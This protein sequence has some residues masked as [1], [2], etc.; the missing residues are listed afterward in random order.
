MAMGAGSPPEV[1]ILGGGLTGISAAYHLQRPWVLLEKNDRLGGHARTD[2][3]DGYHFDKTG[4]WLH[5]RD[6]YTKGLIGELLGDDMVKVERKARIFSN[7]V[8]TR[9]PFQANL[10]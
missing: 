7:G 9:F 8:L 2:Q 1:V 4:H 10:H 6:A 5:L 3:R